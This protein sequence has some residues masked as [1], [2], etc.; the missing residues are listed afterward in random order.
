M[1]E[2]FNPLFVHADEVLKLSPVAHEAVVFLINQFDGWLAVSAAPADN[3]YILALKAF[4]FG[5]TLVHVTL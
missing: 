4:K 3:A 5:L 1:R 2:I